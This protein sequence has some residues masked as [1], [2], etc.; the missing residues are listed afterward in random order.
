MS[1]ADADCRNHCAN[2][3]SVTV[4]GKSRGNAD[5]DGKD[6]DDEDD[7][8]GEADDEDD[9]AA[10]P[11]SLALAQRSE[12]E[13]TWMASAKMG[14]R[15]GLDGLAYTLLG[16]APPAPETGE[17]EK[18]EAEEEEEED[19]AGEEEDDDAGSAEE[20]DAYFV[21]DGRARIAS[22]SPVQ[23][24]SANAI[25]RTS[26]ARATSDHDNVVNACANACSGKSAA[27]ERQRADRRAHNGRFASASGVCCCF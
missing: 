7:E 23:S 12:R 5:D 26:S 27:A 6:D 14:Q 21:V 9:D 19:E 3:T 15:S 18:A 4:L 13:N 8:E 11:L 1:L 24:I 17:E 25:A 20:A 16:R 10:V 2:T 22:R